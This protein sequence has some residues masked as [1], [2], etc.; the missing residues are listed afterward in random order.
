MVYIC[1]I[2]LYCLLA[3]SINLKYGNEVSFSSGV[4]I[5]LSL[6]FLALIVARPS[7][8]PDYKNYFS[9]YA[10]DAGERF[11][12]AAK[13]IKKI[14]PS[15][16]IF[17]LFFGICGFCVKMVAIKQNT[18]YHNLV[19]F[20]YLST[21]FILH[22]LI[23]IRASCAIAIFLFS[24]K[25]LIQKNYAKYYLLIFVST[26]FH[27]SAV[28]FLFVPILCMSN[29]I[30][31]KFWILIILFSYVLY[32]L[33]LDFISLAMIIIPKN[34]YIFQTLNFFAGKRVNVFN[35]GQILKI[36]IFLY[37]LFHNEELDEV[38]LL[39][40]KLLGTSVVLFPLLASISVLSFRVSELFG[41]SI[42]FLLPEL[43]NKN[44][45]KK[46][47]LM[48]FVSFEVGLFFINNIICGYIF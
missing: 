9:F 19:L 2:L 23:Q 26:L 24:L 36:I 39:S 25:Y 44:D 1:L 11:E 14:S 45:S 17:L 7:Y 30:S 33:H 48:V 43:L 5:L 34:T 16:Y 37:F 27:Y 15:F 46:Y 42:I 29:K 4:F 38:G 8:F 3:F 20:T 35:V 6:F 40:L 41:S 12:P 47:Y 31:V 32:F 13:I 10:G 28:L 22:D 18:I 21:T